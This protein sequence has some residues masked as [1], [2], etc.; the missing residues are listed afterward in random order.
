MLLINVIDKVECL[1]FCTDVYPKKFFDILPK[2]LLRPRWWIAADALATRPLSCT[3]RYRAIWRNPSIHGCLVATSAKKFVRGTAIPRP[4][5]SQGSHP[6]PGSAGPLKIGRRRVRRRLPKPLGDQPRRALGSSGF[7]ATSRPPL[8]TEALLNVDLYC[9]QYAVGRL[10]EC[11]GDP[12]HVLGLPRG[13][14]RR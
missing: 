9:L 2:P 5:K 7:N 3:E 1:K 4:T 8:A 11:Y 13:V 6:V 12:V 14:E 10:V